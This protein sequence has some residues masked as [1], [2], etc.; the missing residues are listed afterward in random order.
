MI[1][2]P[3]VVRRAI[4][5][6]ALLCVTVLRSTLSACLLAHWLSIGASAV[7][8]VNPGFETGDF[9][10][11]SVNPAAS[12]AVVSSYTTDDGRTYTPKDGAFFARLEAGGIA[13]SNGEGL[14]F[15]AQ[16]FDM[17]AGESISGW[18]GFDARDQLPYDDR[19]VVVVAV[20]GVGQQLLY[21]KSVSDVGDYGSSAWESWS[22]TAPV[23]SQY[24]L[25][26][27]VRNVG[28]NTHN[29]RAVFD[30]ARVPDGGS[31]F[32]LVGF[33]LMSSVAFRHLRWRRI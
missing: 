16:A 29:S 9:T 21:E 11:W 2:N 14:T 24:I 27:S 19:G 18:A 32:P 15:V 28:D 31:T 12:A 3:V 22:F 6:V 7:S 13:L 8:I 20:L 5:K 23:A 4:I 17:L 33:G 30:I 1:A 26:F 10:G 25:A